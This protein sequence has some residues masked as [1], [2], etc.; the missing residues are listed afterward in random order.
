MQIG[1]NIKSFR[2]ENSLTQKD[3][4]EKLHVTAQAVSRW[5][6]DEVQ[7]DLDTIQ[8]MANIF[9]VSIEEIINGKKVEEPA[10]VEEQKVEPT[11]VA[12]PVQ[13]E[14]APAPRQM[15]AL[16][17][18]CNT[19]I[20]NSE[21]IHR[22][23]FKRVVGHARS[24]HTEID[25]KIYC[26]TCY[27]KYQEEQKAKAIFAENEMHR[28]LKRRRI[29][30]F[31]WPTLF[32]ILMIIC[33][34]SFTKDGDDTTALGAYFLAGAGFFMGGC[35]ILGNNFLA[36]TFLSICSWSI[37]F[38]GIIFTLDLDGILALIFIKILFGLI[39]IFISILC[40]FLAIF[41]CGALSIFVYPYALVKNLKYIDE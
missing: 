24:H 30:S 36:D 2:S 15:L 25:K 22:M 35:F 19:P 11:P 17:E 1:N 20:Y 12:A 31:I 41:V 32:A 37:K 18:K 29:H 14:P 8:E 9:N 10:P 6:N 23:E 38:P 27:K 16:C 21:D 28:K 3:L 40:F 33:G 13:P 5:E 7:P 26:S 34:I 39:S 4:A